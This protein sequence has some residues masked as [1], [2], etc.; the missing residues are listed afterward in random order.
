[1]QSGWLVNMLKGAAAVEV[2]MRRGVFVQPGWLVVNVLK[3]AAVEAEMRRGVF[4]QS[5]WLVV[6]VLKAAAVEAEMRRGVFV[7][8]A[9]VEAEMR[10]GVFV[11]VIARLLQVS[12]WHVSRE[13]DLVPFSTFLKFEIRKVSSLVRNLHHP[14]HSGILVVA[15]HD[16]F[17]TARGTTYTADH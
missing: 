4:V 15:I 12:R 9:A 16:I 17:S 8:A 14:N 7:L 11:L 6:N 10:R 3:A 13:F 2:E 5:G 1:M